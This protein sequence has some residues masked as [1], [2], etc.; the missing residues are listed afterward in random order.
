MKEINE[1][2]VPIK[3]YEGLY[4]VSNTGCYKSLERQVY[5]KDGTPLYKQKEIVSHNL[6][7]YGDYII[8]TLNKNGARKMFYLHVVVANHFVDN[9]LNL[10]YVNHKDGNKLNNNHCNLEFCTLS[11]N[12]KHAYRTGLHTPLYGEA[13]QNTK[14]TDN[15]INEIRIAYNT[16]L[17][18]Q[19]SLANMYNVS[20]CQIHNIVTN[21]QRNSCYIQKS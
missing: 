20:Q 14:L 11:E 7:P 19:R 1:I 17:Y 15:E 4:E 5:K 2:W 18:S 12:Q 6:K 16:N 3:G 10:P 13:H 9:P 8:L 21:K